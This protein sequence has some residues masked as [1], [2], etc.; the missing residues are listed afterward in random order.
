MLQL[1]LCLSEERSQQGTGMI[2]QGA[3]LKL[4]CPLPRA[5]HSARGTAGTFPVPCQPALD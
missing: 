4:G 1:R 5:A 3:A 2:A